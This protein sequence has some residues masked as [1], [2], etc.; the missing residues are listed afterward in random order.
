MGIKNGYKVMFTTQAAQELKEVYSYI[1]NKL[2]SP[3]ATLELMR[4]INNKVV[5]ISYFPR[6]Y[7]RLITKKIK[8]NK[9]RKIVIKNYIILYQIHDIKREIEIVHIFNSK[10]NYIEKL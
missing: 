6:M 10:S 8:F 1:S 7:S 9:Y 5:N 4:E 2:Y 3:K